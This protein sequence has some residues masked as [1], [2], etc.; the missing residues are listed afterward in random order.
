MT[1]VQRARKSARTRATTTVLPSDSKSRTER[2]RYDRFDSLDGTHPWAEAMPDGCVLYRVR[3][4]QRG[5][6]AYFNFAL[7]KEMGLIPSSHS[8]QLTL[9]LKQKLLQTFSLQIL[10]EYDEQ[11]TKTHKNMSLKP[12]RYMASRYLQL[13]HANKQG[14]TSGDGRGIWNGIVEHQGRTWDVSSRG[15]GVTCLS[16][17]S[18][19]AQKPLRT[20]NTQFGYG[21]GLA[22]IDELL[23]AA[24]FAEIMH[25]QGLPTERVLCVIDLGGDYGIGV[26]AAP[27]LLRPAHLFRYLKQNRLPELKR[28]TDYFI[29]RQ[30]RNGELDRPTKGNRYFHLLQD[31]T[32]RFARFAARLEVD[33]IFA[34]LDW[35]GDNVLMDAGIIDYGSVRQFGLRHDQYRYDDVERFSTNLNEQKQK[36]RL[37]V[38]VFAQMVD[39]LVTGVRR[40][41]GHFANDPQIQVFETEF[42]KQHWDRLFYRM[43]FTPAQRARLSLKPELCR[44]WLKEFS[45]FERAKVSGS[46]RRVAD[47]INH[48]A[49]FNMRTALRI[50]AEHFVKVT[51]AGPF[52]AAEELFPQIVSQFAKQQDARLRP[53]HSAHLDS[54]QKLY[55]QLLEVAAGTNNPALIL[56]GI[57]ERS[58]EL[59]RRQRVT[60]NALIQIVNELLAQMKKGMSHNDLQK[61]IDQLVFN[62]LGLPEIKLDRGYDRKPRLI[63]QSDI[64][65]KL[66]QIID[67]HH[68]DI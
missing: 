52:L 34:W 1:T 27:N 28:G 14:K 16:P 43:G 63:R 7:A 23:A 49:L 15:T 58:R 3:E 10:N 4:L 53:K 66:I 32:A 31:L 29:Q 64:F 54:L 35:D 50:L 21:C 26:R 20:G 25:L 38:Q 17:G 68:E 57:A 24:I 2:S 45:Y 67:S 65:A 36:A 42:Q 59:N 13:Q 5:E 46:S 44:A 62:H 41:L 48:P 51:A 11:Q 30:T 56:H 6:I 40:P 39:F 60:G 33:Y 9:G 8:N 22:E 61:L 37:L 55:V 12:N 18:V 47:G 19:E